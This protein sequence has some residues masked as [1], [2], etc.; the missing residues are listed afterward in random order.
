M[1]QPSKKTLE[2]KK[3]D[4]SVTL[5][6]TNIITYP[7]AETLGE[8]NKV[9]DGYSDRLFLMAEKEQDTR[10]EREKLKI[11]L[12]HKR[13]NTTRWG[14]AIGALVVFPLYGLSFYAFSLGNAVEGAAIVVGS[15]I[16]NLAGIFVARKTGLFD[17]KKEEK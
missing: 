4:E 11:K 13:E 9:K 15:T 2:A 17:D 6:E 14:M 16:A 12:A 10:I 5:S 1:S 7:S 3:G 8:Y